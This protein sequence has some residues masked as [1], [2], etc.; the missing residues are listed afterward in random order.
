MPEH[1]RSGIDENILGP[2]LSRRGLRITD[3]WEKKG[4]ITLLVEL[5]LRAQA[6]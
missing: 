1:S 2:E 4:V 5:D 3:R 6:K